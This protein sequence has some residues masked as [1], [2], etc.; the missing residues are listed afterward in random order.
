MLGMGLSD[1]IRAAVN[2]RMDRT[3]KK[4]YINRVKKII[5]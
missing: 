3:V 5:Y 2:R 1:Q 4:R